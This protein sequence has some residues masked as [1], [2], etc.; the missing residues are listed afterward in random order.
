MKLTLY[1]SGYYTHFSFIL[2][3]IGLTLPFTYQLKYIIL[4]NSIVVGIAGNFIFIKDYK[5]YLDWYHE[6]EPTKVAKLSDELI[7]GNFI[8]H[9]LPMIISFVLLSSCFPYMTLYKDALRYFIVILAMIMVWSL[10]PYN[11]LI[12]S[13]KVQNAYPST[14]FAL[15]VT[16]IGMITVFVM[17]TYLRHTTK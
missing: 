3:F 4:L 7:A 13:E 8:C 17:M 5:K 14:S 11:G 15:V 6:N 10:F 1:Y 16:F 12:V 2:F 9:T